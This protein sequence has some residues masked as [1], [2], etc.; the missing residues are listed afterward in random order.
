MT[1]GML[2]L[3][4]KNQYTTIKLYATDDA[5]YQTV[6]STAT[7]TLS[8]FD[9]RD[10]VIAYME[11]NDVTANGEYEYQVV[12]ESANY[13][14]VYATEKFVPITQA[15]EFD[16]LIY[17]S[18]DWNG[19]ATA[20]A[21]NFY[22]LTTNID[23]SSY[24]TWTGWA[25]NGLG[26]SLQF[27]FD[28]RGYTITNTYTYN[29][30]N[31]YYGLA[32]YW[33]NGTA[34]GNVFKRVWKNVHYKLDITCA[35]GSVARSFIGGAISNYDFYNCYFD[36][37]VTDNTTADV[38]LFS[39]NS[40]SKMTNCVIQITEKG[41]NTTKVVGNGDSTDG[42][43]LVDCVV[44]SSKVSETSVV[45]NVANKSA[46][47]NAVYGYTT[48]A[49]FVAGN[50]GYKATCSRCTG[51]GNSGFARRTGVEPV[52]EADQTAGRNE[53]AQ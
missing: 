41:S 38:G 48:L 5:N 15:S 22:F 1:D 28:G 46:T 9:V 2:V 29:M 43:S 4:T 44:I 8:T 32:G 34:N 33:G 45:T 13:K 24:N 53:S 30:T 21:G 51:S 49:N 12:V 3:N 42:G 17:D 52:H 20:Q 35:D 23:I 25:Q 14:G 47:A 10:F 11:A 31:N 39:L 26:L 18:A 50:S 6:L 36:V 19:A 27:S 37:T 40:N 7:T 16:A